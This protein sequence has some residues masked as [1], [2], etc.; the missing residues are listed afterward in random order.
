MIIKSDELAKILNENINFYLLYGINTGFIED[1]IEGYF[2]L[3]F[4]KNIFNYDEKEILINKNN[5][6][7]NV[8]NISLFDD[9]KLIIINRATDK[10]F[11]IIEDLSKTKFNKCKI[12]LKSGVLEKKSKLRSLFEKSKNK[13]VIP[14]YEDNYKSLHSIVQKFLKENNIKL[15]T[16]VINHV[17]EKSKGDRIF[18]KKQLEKICSLSLSK[19]RISLFE[20]KKLTNVSSNF[21]MTELADTCLLKDLKKTQKILN[22]TILS[23][24]NNIM[25]LKSFLFKLK[26]LKIISEKFNEFKNLEKTISL[27]KP[28]IFWKDKNIIFQQ[29]KKLSLNDI[30]LLIREINNLEYKIKKNSSISSL[31]LQ[32]YIFK[33]V[34]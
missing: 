15:S 2:K 11:N 33:I 9:N 12:V 20:I 10:I 31:L 14:F 17:I 24:E 32:N 8:L 19:K 13:I 1:V 6:I 3:N 5:L 22:E 16:E 28:P 18:L 4:S 27:I 26:R 25:L 21:D 30:N 34:N 7:E 23:N 29:L